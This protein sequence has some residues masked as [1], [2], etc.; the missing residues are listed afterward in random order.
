MLGDRH[1]YLRSLFATR[2]SHPRIAPELRAGL[3]ARVAAF[4]HGLRYTHVALRSAPPV[5]GIIEIH[6]S[7]V[8]GALVRVAK[9][10]CAGT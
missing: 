9:S 5:E 4:V 8:R 2:T 3:T 6:R 1:R 10:W 7:A